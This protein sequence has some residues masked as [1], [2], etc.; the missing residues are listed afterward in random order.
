MMTLAVP[1]VAAARRFFE[2]GLGWKVNSTAPGAHAS[3]YAVPPLVGLQKAP[4]GAK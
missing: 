4:E 2:T 1:D 3:G